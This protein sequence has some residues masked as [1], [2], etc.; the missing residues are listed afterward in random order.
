MDNMRQKRTPFDI[1]DSWYSEEEVFNYLQKNDIRD[2]FSKVPTDIKSKEFA[3]W[4]TLQ[5]KLAMSK[6]IQLGR[7][8]SRDFN[9][10]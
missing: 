7:D 8:G 6:G 4:L 10:D 1:A 3:R 2:S 9:G 5:Y